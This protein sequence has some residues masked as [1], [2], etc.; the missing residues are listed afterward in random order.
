MGQSL[1]VLILVRGCGEFISPMLKV[2]VP[3]IEA[4]SLILHRDAIKVD[5]LVEAGEDLI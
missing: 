4:E 3:G 5:M 1:M 2:A